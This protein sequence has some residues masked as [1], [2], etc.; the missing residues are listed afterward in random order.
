MV[1]VLLMAVW[2]GSGTWELEWVWV[3][4]HLRSVHR[5]TETEV[6]NIISSFF[7]YITYLIQ[8]WLKL[9]LFSGVVLIK[10]L[11]N[12]FW[13]SSKGKGHRGITR[14]G[15]LHWKCIR[16][17]KHHQCSLVKGFLL[18]SQIPTLPCLRRGKGWVVSECVESKARVLN[19][20]K[21]SDQHNCTE[22]PQQ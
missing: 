14:K 8:M 3:C 12:C 19:G 15:I 20:F 18:V 9:N 17:V 6:V 5:N 13:K 4:S 16:A 22:E 7:I 2:A 21:V 10:K 1:E 11:F